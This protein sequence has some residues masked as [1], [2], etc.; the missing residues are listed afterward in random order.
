MAQNVRCRF[1]EIDLVM[2]DGRM[3]VIVEVRYRQRNAYASAALSVSRAKQQKIALAA[4]WFLGRHPRLADLPL[5]FD[6]VAFDRHGRFTG[7][8][9]DGCELQWM[10]DAFRPASP[11]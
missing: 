10:Q 2:R 1:G 5:R 9:G 6:V 7:T 8:S 11:F 3:L 4:N